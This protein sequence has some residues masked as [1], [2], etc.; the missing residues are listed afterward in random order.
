M[1]FYK[2]KLSQIAFLFQNET[3]Q[4]VAELSVYLE[5]YCGKNNINYCKIRQVK[6]RLQIDFTDINVQ[7][8]KKIYEECNKK[9][10]EKTMT[11]SVWFVV[12]KIYKLNEDIASFE[13][14]NKF[15]A[16]KDFDDIDGTKATTIPL[17]FQFVTY[18]CNDRYYC[19]FDTNDYNK[20]EVRLQIVY[21]Q[22]QDIN[23][24]IENFDKVYKQILI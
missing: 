10:N 17:E 7:N 5:Q 8:M 9:I 16:I 22:Q 24:I 23:K 19:T 12:S 15:V 11:Y 6:L 1:E 21:E 18:I 13:Y 3:E 14:L 2:N 4:N 20:I